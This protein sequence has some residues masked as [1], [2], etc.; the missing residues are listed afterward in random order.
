MK[1]HYIIPEQTIAQLTIQFQLLKLSGL[2]DNNGSGNGNGGGDT[3]Q[4][5]I[6]DGGSGDGSDADVRGWDGFE[7][8]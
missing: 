3:S 4:T 1:K 6:S 5:D 7:T 2:D 8:W